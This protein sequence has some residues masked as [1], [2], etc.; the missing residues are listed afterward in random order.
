MATK[1]LEFDSN[2]KFAKFFHKSIAQVQDKFNMSRKDAL[3]LIINM[4]IIGNNP[5]SEAA[6]RAQEEADRILALR[7][8]N[9]KEGYVYFLKTESHDMFKVGATKKSP[10][11]RMA[12]VQSGCPYKIDLYGYLY[13]SN[14]RKMEKVFHRK[15]E[16]YRMH[17]EWFEVSPAIIRHLIVQEVIREKKHPHVMNVPVEVFGGEKLRNE[18]R[19]ALAELDKEQG[20]ELNLTSP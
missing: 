6:A 10:Y 19:A 4:A 20:E 17:G 12:T 2:D 16:Q 1:M 18:W 14:C 8:R 13:Y 5:S 9:H 3:G 11:L 7:N 15:L